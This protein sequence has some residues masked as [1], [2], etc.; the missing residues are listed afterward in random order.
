MVYKYI[1]FETI[2]LKCPLMIRNKYGC[3]MYISTELKAYWLIGIQIGNQLI[4]IQCDN[5]LIAFYSAI[6]SIIMPFVFK[7][8]NYPALDSVINQVFD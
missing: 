7:S 1:V 3:Q 4:G 6:K 5:I 2:K 8:V